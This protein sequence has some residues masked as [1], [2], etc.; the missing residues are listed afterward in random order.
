MRKI[1]EYQTGKSLMGKHV[2]NTSIECVLHVC[3]A[4]RKTLS[5]MLFEFTM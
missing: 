4:D 2:F 5:I 3:F 1:N